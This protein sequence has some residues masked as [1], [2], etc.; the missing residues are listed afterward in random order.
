MQDKTGR[1]YKLA[2]IVMKQN[3]LLYDTPRALVDESLVA[4]F[5]KGMDLIHLYATKAKLS[6][7]N[8]NDIDAYINKKLVLH[9]RYLTVITSLPCEHCSHGGPWS[10]FY[11]T[12]SGKGRR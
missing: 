3:R 1:Y 8:Q 6:K 7:K 11:N 5:Q 10:I 9:A 12:S 2:S 4:E